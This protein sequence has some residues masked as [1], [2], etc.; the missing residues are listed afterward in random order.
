MVK[1]QP[2]H[3]SIA[4][5]RGVIHEHSIDKLTKLG[6]PKTSIKSFL[7]N[8]HQN[9]IRFLTYLVLNNRK[10]NNRKV[11]VPHPNVMR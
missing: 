5:V 10:F 1:D 6:I 8:I 4:K 2:P 7:K 11:H 9:A 3:T